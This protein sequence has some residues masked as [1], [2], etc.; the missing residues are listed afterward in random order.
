MLVDPETRPD[1]M[2]ENVAMAIAGK[3]Q[4][5]SDSGVS[6]PEMQY[7]LSFQSRVGPVQWLK[8]YTE[9]KLVEL[10]G[11]GVKNLVVVPVSFVSE[12]IETLEEIDIEY[13]T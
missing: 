12:H 9:T 5:D 2:Q 4:S 11:R 10:G 6:V 8:P 1:S 3:L 7:H 13:V